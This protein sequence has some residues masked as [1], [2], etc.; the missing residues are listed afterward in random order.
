MSRLTVGFLIGLVAASASAQTRLNIEHFQ[1]NMDGKGLFATEGAEMLQPK[2]FA[3]GLVLH[4]ARE[5]LRA[6]FLGQPTRQVVTGRLTADLLV[7]A[8]ITSWL[9]VGLASPFV[10]YNQLTSA[11][12]GAR[13]GFGLGPT[14]AELKFGAGNLERDGFGIAF[15]PRILFSGSSS[16]GFLS[17]NEPVFS[18]LLV[19]GYNLRKEVK[20][21]GVPW[22][23][24]LFW[25]FALGFQLSDQVEV[26]GEF[27]GATS[28]THPF[29]GKIAY[30]PMEVLVGARYKF[31]SNALFEV[32][33]GPGLDQGYGTPAFRVF[34]GIMVTSGGVEPDKDGDGVPDKADKCPDV[35]GPRENQ[36]CPWPD[37]DGDG[38]LDKDDRCPDVAGPRENQGCPWPD[39]D[40][41]GVLDKDDKCPGE[42]GPAENQ[43][44]PWPDQDK[45]GVPDKDDKCPNEAG[46]KENQGCPVPKDT[47]GDGIPDKDD[48]CPNEAGPRENQGCPWPDGDKDGV[49]DKDDKCPREP[50]PAENQGCPWPDRDKDGVPDKDDNCPDQP[51]PASNKGCPEKGPVL[52]KDEVKID[53]K[54]MFKTGSATILK[55]SY[56]ILNAVADLMKKF[57]DQ[58]KK[59]EVQG[60]TD[61]VGSAKANKR[62]S[63]RRAEAVM[64]YLV[65][66]G[67]SKKRLSAKGF[68]P[69]QPLVQ[70]DKKKMSKAELK[71][72]REQNRRVQFKIIK[73]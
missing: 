60:H 38:V 3:L 35:V 33:F 72:A 63:Q 15:I 59:V 66:K 19:L 11:I 5:P 40:G 46:P 52:T 62:L 48:R 41:D 50:G 70:V 34:G 57:P 56:G 13:G 30:N 23:D 1:P 28:A 25:R 17:D 27:L 54:V 36:G 51:G 7:N 55:K 9:Q 73:D 20:V 31:A 67:I 71:A 45:D 14:R 42:P 39:R 2:E 43:G 29:G 68:G 65:K 4:Y 16:D 21:A 49:L 8:G 32:G 61:D 58:T 64:K 24:E 12:P 26:G 53:E 47:D 6:A 37:R 44:C 69:E 22:G 10:F 18:P